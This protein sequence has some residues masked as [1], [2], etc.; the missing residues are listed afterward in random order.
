MSNIAQYVKDNDIPT[1]KVISGRIL[2]EQ[3]IEIWARDNND[4][5]FFKTFI[6]GFTSNGMAC[7]ESESLSFNVGDYAITDKDLVDLLQ[8]EN[9]HLKKKIDHGRSTLCEMIVVRDGLSRDLSRSQRE[10]DTAKKNL[11]I[12]QILSSIVIIILS[13]MVIK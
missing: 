7:T 12:F 1:G 9:C 6:H 2:L 13:I 3:P 10:T 5:S 11:L 8:S 4:N